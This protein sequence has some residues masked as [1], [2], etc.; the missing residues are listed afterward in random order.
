MTTDWHIAGR[1][2]SFAQ[3]PLILGIVNL[4]PD[5]FSDGGQ[6]NDTA[7]AVHHALKLVEQ[8]ADLLDLGG[9]STRPGSLPISAGDELARVVPVVAELRKRTDVPLSID[10]SKA[11]VARQ[12]LALGA[13]IVNDVTALRDP[14]MLDVVREYSAGVILMHMQGTP[15]TMQAQPQYDDVIGDIAAFFAERIQICEA[16]GVTREKLVLDPGLGFGK[17]FEHNLEILVRL[18]AFL[19]LGRPICLGVSRKG[20]LGQITGRP[21]SERAVSTALLG[22]YGA[23]HGAAHLQRVHDIAET[24]DA[25]RMSVALRQAETKY[26]K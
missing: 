18:E 15:E 7:A 9:E 24:L 16:A 21:R 26:R 13:H 25:V 23:M 11:E 8:G 5:S 17:T 6:H 1:T 3:R 4:T 22:F 14:D 2:L 10:T 20:F 12:C 19:A